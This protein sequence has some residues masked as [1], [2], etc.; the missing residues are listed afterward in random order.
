VAEAQERLLGPDGKLHP[1][2]YTISELALVE[3]TNDDPT[4]VLTKVKLS[5]GRAVHS[6]RRRQLAGYCPRCCFVSALL[7]AD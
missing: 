7:A 4:K 2:E 1:A 6:D 3:T 5:R